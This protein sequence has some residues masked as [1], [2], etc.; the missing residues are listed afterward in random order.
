[1]QEVFDFTDDQATERRERSQ[2]A[3]SESTAER[4][5]R[6]APDAPSPPRF[7][8][9]DLDRDGWRLYDGTE[10]R[11]LTDAQ[12]LSG[13][14][15]DLETL[16]VESAHLVPQGPASV[17]APFTA[18]QLEKLADNA[19][20]GIRTVPHR[21]MPRVWSEVRP[22]VAWD[23]RPKDEDTVVWHEYLRGG[24]LRNAKRWKPRPDPLPQV[25]LDLRMEIMSMANQARQARQYPLAP[26]P[27]ELSTQ[28][29]RVK[30][31]AWT[32]RDV[33]EQSAFARL[34]ITSMK[35]AF[36]SIYFCDAYCVAR[37]QDGEPRPRLSAR[38]VRRICGLNFN[39]YPNLI[40][41]NLR[42][43]LTRNT[44]RHPTDVD[45]A[46]VRVALALNKARP[47]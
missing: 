37:D 9:L 29:E 25:V 27:Q 4:P 10:V 32:A 12:V 38:L 28:M 19:D 26:Y 3:S 8:V 17:A 33:N 45:K 44:G 16:I 15:G 13:R 18:E 20:C 46:F 39:G 14:F 43:H 30:A 34:G 23:E 6:R 31:W 5:R 42:H 11:R 21:R 24:R 22:D 36:D 47:T 2:T 7:G 40:R 1:L 35:R 41:A